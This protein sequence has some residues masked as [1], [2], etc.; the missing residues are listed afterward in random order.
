MLDK[1]DYDKAI[2][3]HACGSQVRV[4]GELVVGRKSTITCESF[5]ILD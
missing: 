1:N 2:E 3:A 4:V 5:S